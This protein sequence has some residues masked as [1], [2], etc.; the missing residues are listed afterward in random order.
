MWF[1]LLGSVLLIFLV[2]C[3]VSFVGVSVAHLFSFLCGFFCWGQCC[4]S[5]KFSVWFLLLGSVLFIILVFCVVFLVGSVL[6]IF[7]VFSV[8][9]FV[10]VSVAHLFS[11]LCGFFCWGQCCS[12]F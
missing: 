2:F 4:S 1:L 9:S 7:L 6:L 8:V 5:F 10:G 11:F 12:S 3:V